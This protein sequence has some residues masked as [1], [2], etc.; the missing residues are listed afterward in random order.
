M[1]GQKQC[2]M[3]LFRDLGVK[4]IIVMSWGGGSINE[5]E[6][7]RSGVCTSV[8]PKRM[9]LTHQTFT[10]AALSRTSHSRQPS[11]TSQ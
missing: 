5:S 1:A 7:H 2:S 10:L 11:H 8:L 9:N 6:S 3:S 4:S